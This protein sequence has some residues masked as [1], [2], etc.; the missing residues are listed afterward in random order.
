MQQLSFDFTFKGN[1]KS[2]SFETW[3]AENSHEKRQFNEK[4][5]TREQAKKVFERLKRQGFFN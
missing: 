5:Y 2:P 4:P 1:K 3:Y